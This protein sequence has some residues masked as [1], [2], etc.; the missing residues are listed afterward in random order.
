MWIGPSVAQIDDP[1]GQ[2][3]DARRNLAFAKESQWIAWHTNH[4]E[5]LSSP[6]VTRQIVQW[7]TPDRPR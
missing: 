5:L 1:L 4:M 6:K 2:H 3:D 7:L